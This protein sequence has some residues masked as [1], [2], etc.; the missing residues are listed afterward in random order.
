MGRSR[1]I[2]AVL[3]VLALAG[4]GSLRAGGGPGH[5]AGTTASTNAAAAKAPAG[6]WAC[7]GNGAGFAASRAFEG[8]GA[9]SPIA[10]ARE[11]ARHPEVP[12]FGTASSMWTVTTRGRGAA[13]L[14]SGHV[15]L[16]AAQLRDGTW[17]IDS[18]KRCD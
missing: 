10:A 18:G 4:C 14:V 1:M 8:H 2:A 3:G 17:W 9:A 5:R 12:G 13:T 15:S 11:F 16:H 6:A 7:E